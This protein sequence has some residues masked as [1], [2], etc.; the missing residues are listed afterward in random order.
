LK[1][2]FCVAAIIAATVNVALAQP[3]NGVTGRWLIQG[4]FGVIAITPC[5]N[6]ICGRID[7]MKPTENGQVSS[8]PRDG[9]N[10]DPA[11]REQPI[12]GLTILYGFRHDDGKHWE[13]GNIYDPESGRTY[14]A[15]ITLVDTNHLRLRG[16]IGIPLLGA[17]QVWT[18]VDNELPQC[19]TGISHAVSA[20][21]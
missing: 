15:N 21:P 8:I 14:H 18:R 9:R 11:R 1:L 7:W 13:A 19:H 5:G 2:V 20:V 6:S 16:Y 10:P 17:S 3:G 4:G 12:C